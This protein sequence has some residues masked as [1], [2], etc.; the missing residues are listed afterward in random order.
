VG[1]IPPDLLLLLPDLISPP[2]DRSAHSSLDPEQE[3]RRLFATFAH[4]FLSQLAKQPGL[5]VVEDVH[6]SD[7]TSLEF[8]HYLARYCAARP[9]L[10]LFTYRSD[11]VR[12]SLEHF[13][14]QLDRERLARELTLAPLVRS[15][16]DAMLR[17]IFSLPPSTPLELPDPIYALTEGNPFFVEEILTSWSL[18]TQTA[19]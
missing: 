6:W 9:L 19:Q 5:L 2:S 16:V 4:F 8:F 13:L 10:L 17:A 3:K 18:G 7:D 15:D 14:V 1:S 11:E 12:P